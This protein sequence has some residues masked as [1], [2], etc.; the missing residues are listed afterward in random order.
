MSTKPDEV[1]NE[2]KQTVA[3]LQREL[4]KMQ[5][6]VRLTTSQ[7]NELANQAHNSAAMQKAQRNQIEIDQIYDRTINLFFY[8]L[9]RLIVIEV[10]LAMLKYQSEKFND[11]A[12]DY[13]RMRSEVYQ[14]LATGER[15]F[16]SLQSIEEMLQLHDQTLNSRSNLYW[17]LTKIEES[18]R[19]RVHKMVPVLVKSVIQ[20]GL[21]RVLVYV[22][23]GILTAVGG[24]VLLERII[25]VLTEGM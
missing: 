10:T 2:N 14:R 18:T 3:D 1:G 5:A 24:T 6:Q 22:I 8:S 9:N 17:L 23:G 12:D 4:R 15:A 20:A 19:K 11:V 21:V 13:R 7:L 16:H 25:A